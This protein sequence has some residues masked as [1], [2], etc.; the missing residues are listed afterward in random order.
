MVRNLTD[1]SLPSSVLEV[2]EDNLMVYIIAGCITG[3]ILI[4]LIVIL[5]SLRISKTR[6]RTEGKKGRR[7]DQ[8]I[9]EISSPTLI[10]SSSSLPGILKDSN[11][12]HVVVNPINSLF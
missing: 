3:I 12:R 11:L 1:P 2:F 5:I 6:R 10:H 9:T 8:Y 4:I 7:N